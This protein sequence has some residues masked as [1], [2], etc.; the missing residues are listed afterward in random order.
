[1]RMTGGGRTI[2]GT[3]SEARAVAVAVTVMGRTGLR[4][5]LLRRE[6]VN[7]CRT[8][9]RRRRR[10]SLICAAT[11]MLAAAVV[12]AAGAGRARGT[13]RGK[14]GRRGEILGMMVKGGLRNGAGGPRKWRSRKVI[15]K[16][17]EVGG[18]RR[19]RSRKMIGK[20]LGG[21]GGRRRRRRWTMKG[22][23][24]GE[25][26]TGKESVAG[27]ARRMA[28]AAAAATRRAQLLGGD[29]AGLLVRIRRPH[30]HHLHRLVHLLLLRLLR[31]PRRLRRPPR[32][33]RHRFAPRRSVL[34]NGGEN[35]KQKKSAS[36]LAEV[37]RIPPP[38]GVSLVAWG[39]SVASM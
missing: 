12:V 14:G 22:K 36:L 6:S 38:A 5:G 26:R 15:G 1:M 34:L 11:M 3:T 24:L 35:R 23:L 19:R 27:V 33:A 13:A 8:I 37:D 4:R 2:M 31:R 21:A 25:C 17:L 29:V 16:L 7:R 10:G 20:L 32:R 28:A 39:R 30:R 9:S 18:P